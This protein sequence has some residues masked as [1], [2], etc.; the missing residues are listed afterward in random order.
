[1]LLS[2]PGW[3]GRGS[4]VPLRGTDSRPRPSSRDDGTARP[5]IGAVL[6]ISF[7]AVPLSGIVGEFLNLAE[8]LHRRGF[9]IYLDLGYD[10]HVYAGNFGR[11]FGSEVGLFP[12]WVKF[13]RVL[14]DPLPAGYTPEVVE[15]LREEVA[16]GTW[17]SPPGR[18][19]AWAWLHDAIKTQI[20]E[21]F[22]RVQ[23]RFVIVENGTLPENPLVTEA[24]Y[25]AIRQYGA[26][27][28][29]GRFVLWRDFDLM[30]SVEKDR[31]GPFPYIGTPRLRNSR[32]IQHVVVTDWMRR[33]VAEWV[34]GVPVAVLPDRFPMSHPDVCSRSQFRDALGIPLHSILIARCTRVIPQKCIERDLRLT[35]LLQERLRHRGIDRD[36][37]LFITGP[38]D[39][40]RAETAK[41]RGLAT[42]LG[43]ER[44]IIWGEGLLPFNPLVRRGFTYK[45]FSVADLL[46]ASDL[47]SFLTSYGFEGFGNPPGE[48]MA[49][50]VPYATSSY[51]LYN[52]VYARRGAV[53]PILEISRTTLCSAPITKSFVTEV[54][55][56]V[57]DTEHRDL[58]VANNCRVCS[59]H[60]S[61][62]QLESDVV[63]YLQ[64]EPATT[65]GTDR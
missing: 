38:T 1:M 2:T 16:N 19:R 49:M 46:N 63:R 36:V 64:L 59:D 26:E 57:L 56:L 42:E 62:E 35:R 22:R 34:P 20:V 54:L 15:R 23:A 8:I 39:E 45:G 25:E 33:R 27:A 10:L 6:G 65:G 37:F 41:L 31:Y 28:R 5:P 32:H 52:E 7:D 12:K 47:S 51:E 43:L 4:G 18:S 24:L 58:V 21:T 11:P 14:G 50:C 61:L 13:L 30:W 3:V 55:R 40:D 48:A 29:L 17:D 44:N 9:P 53:A 60:F